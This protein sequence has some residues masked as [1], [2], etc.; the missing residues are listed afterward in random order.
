MLEDLRDYGLVWQR[1]VQLLIL[2]R[3]LPSPDLRRRPSVSVL[4]VWLP[5]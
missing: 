4:P 1:K 2:L 3:E 5:R